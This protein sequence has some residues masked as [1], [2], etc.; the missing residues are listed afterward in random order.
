M[1]C[2]C[3]NEVYRCCEP[4]YTVFSRGSKRKKEAHIWHLNQQRLAFIVA[5][6]HE[7]RESNFFS[8]GYQNLAFLSSS[9]CILGRVRPETLCAPLLTGEYKVKN[10]PPSPGR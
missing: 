10:D 8:S 9:D 4:D 2:G 1:K 7:A 3:S 6:I 5:S